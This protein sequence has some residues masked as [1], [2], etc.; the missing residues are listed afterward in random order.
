MNRIPWLAVLLFGCASKP[1]TNE[2]R[3]A[4]EMPA[5]A[6][7]AMTTASTTAVPT[8]APPQTSAAAA[9][10]ATDTAQAKPEQTGAVAV[11]VATTAAPTTTPAS[12][13]PPPKV[14]A[15][16]GATCGSTR[17][18]IR[19]PICCAGPPKE[20]CQGCQSRDPNAPDCQA[21]FTAEA[22]LT[23]TAAADCPHGGLDR[24]KPAPWACT[25][26]EDCR[27][28]T[29]CCFGSGYDGPPRGAKCQ[30]L[31][32]CTSTGG[33]PFCREWADCVRFGADERRCEPPTEFPGWMPPDLNVCQAPMLRSNAR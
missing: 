18:P 26:N 2:P 5:S 29:V 27:A 8:I 14:A 3:R 9:P 13:K 7:T 30:T 6:P 24:L 4:P 12:P 25:A 20:A 1:L 19:R 28:G 31:K 32:Q 11:P 16:P 10:E 23:C 15:G 21:C 17:C 22:K 33:E